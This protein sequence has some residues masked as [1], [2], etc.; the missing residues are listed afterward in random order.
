MNVNEQLENEWYAVRHSGE[1]PEIALHSS[2][3]YLAQAEDGPRLA[4][5]D[6][7]KMQLKQA[8]AERFK[9]IVLRDMIYENRGLSIYRGIKRSIINYRRYQ[10]FCRRQEMDGTIYNGEIGAVL[11]DFLQKEQNAPGIG[12]GEPVINC[13][14][15]ELTCFAVEVGMSPESLPAGTEEFCSFR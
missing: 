2:L 10:R 12:G 15:E 4:L 1:I 8:A 9:E 14:F 7:Q 6:Q 5:T 11:L 13:T 3:H